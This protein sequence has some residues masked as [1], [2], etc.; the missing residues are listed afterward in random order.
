METDFRGIGN[1]LG[2]SW[3]KIN[4]GGNLFGEWEHILREWEL[5]WGKLKLTWAHG[6]RG[7]SIGEKELIFGERN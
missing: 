5:I 1:S 7:N 2:G 4:G 3:L 6:E